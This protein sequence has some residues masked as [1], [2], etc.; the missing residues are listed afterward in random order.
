MHLD[1]V[2]PRVAVIGD[3]GGHLAAL[4]FELVRLGADPHTGVLPP[5]L[6]VVQVG[7]L[8]HRGPDSDEVV[9]LVDRYLREQPGQ[10][11]Q[12]V[13]N[14]EA[15]YLGESVFYWRERIGATAA[16]TLRRWWADG[17]MRVAASVR[18]TAGDYLV[19]HAGLTAGFWRSVLGT[20]ITATATA[21]TLN[22]LVGHRDSAVFRT[23][24]MMGRRV[25]GSA[26]PLW[27]EASYELVPSWF[28]TRLPFGQIH[29]H[30]SIVDWH[31][32]TMRGPDAVVARTFANPVARHEITT[33]DGG[34]IIGIDPGHGVDPVPLWAAWEAR[35]VAPVTT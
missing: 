5:N 32:A 27:A 3:V 9:A 15:L 28:Q 4:R 6:T 14:H 31:T 11:I 24:A 25:S 30:S 12:I 18:T 23:G 13:G 21:A 1:G 2:E 35:L 34:Q 19:T 33:L 10:W 17:S 29:G 20:P 8:V 7:D 16:A 26:G 22:R